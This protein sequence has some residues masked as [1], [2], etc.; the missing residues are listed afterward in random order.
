MKSAALIV[1]PS[2]YASLLDIEGSFGILPLAAEI[3][4]V[5][6]RT[7]VATPSTWRVERD[8]AS[9]WTVAWAW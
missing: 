8:R 4:V 2:T 1:S 6:M 3:E 5:K 9:L 7:T